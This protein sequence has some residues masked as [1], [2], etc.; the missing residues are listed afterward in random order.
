M[1]K[2]LRDQLEGT[3]AE[4]EWYDVFY[5][6]VFTSVYAYVRQKQAEFHTLMFICSSIL[7]FYFLCSILLIFNWP[8]RGLRTCS[9]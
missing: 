5:E 9:L 8:A 4:T 1:E 6:A 7:G 2:I 3:V